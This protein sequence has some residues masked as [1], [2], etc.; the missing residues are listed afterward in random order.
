MPRGLDRGRESGLDLLTLFR[1]GPLTT[2]PI[3]VPQHWIAPFPRD[4]KHYL[5]MGLL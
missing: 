5:D 4:E 3:D 1:F 2:D